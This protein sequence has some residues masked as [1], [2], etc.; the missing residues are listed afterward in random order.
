M[1]DHSWQMSEPVLSYV[2]M[3]LNTFY[4]LCHVLSSIP[5]SSLLIRYAQKHKLCSLIDTVKFNTLKLYS[6]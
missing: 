3:C 4:S 2:D 1:S 5:K 6:T